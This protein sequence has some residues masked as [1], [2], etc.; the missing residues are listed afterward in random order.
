MMKRITLVISSLGPGGAERVFSWLSNNLVTHGYKVTMLLL[1]NGTRPP[2]F[3]ISPE[4]SVLHLNLL[5]S[6]NGF[7]DGLVNNLRRILVLRK[8]IQ[9]SRPETVISFMDST[10]IITLLATRATGIR[11]VIAER[12]NPQHTANNAYWKFLQKN[13]YQLADKIVV[14]TERVTGY[15]P[16][17]VQTK[18]VVIPN[19]VVKPI[20]TSQ[21][22]IVLQ[23]PCIMG[24]GRL[25]Y[26]KGFDILIDAFTELAQSYPDWRLVIFGDGPAKSTLA[27]QII[28][29]GLE[30]RIFLPG[31]AMEIRP[32]FA[33]ADIFVLPSRLEGFP[34]ALCEAMASGIAVIA[35]DCSTGPREIIRHGID[36]MLVPINNHKALV[37]AM[38]R[39]ILDTTFREQLAKQAPVVC[40]RFHPDGIF[41]KWENLFITG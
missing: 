2:F 29:Y 41:I 34:N 28:T 14:Q 21:P 19:P 4:I 38:E 26:E 18:C 36:G 12:T 33:Y 37:R 8:A 40:E 23:R 11:T 10:N 15:F 13:V 27:A 25:S 31:Y 32:L 35:T 17:R 1:D 6:S 5:K 20:A 30:D 7:L 24:V 16:K 39:L 3:D 22:P 9:E